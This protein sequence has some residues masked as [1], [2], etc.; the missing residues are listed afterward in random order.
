FDIRENAKKPRR[1]ERRSK[2]DAVMVASKLSNEFF[3]GSIKVKIPR[4]LMGRW[5]AG[6]ARVLPP[7]LL[8]GQYSSDRHFSQKPPV[9]RS[10]GAGRRRADRRH[11][12]VAVMISRLSLGGSARKSR[13]HSR[14]RSAMLSS[15]KTARRSD[16]WLVRSGALP[17][18]LEPIS[19]PFVAPG[20]FCSRLAAAVR[21]C[22][23]AAELIGRRV[24]LFGLGRMG[25]TRWP[26]ESRRRG[27]PR[28][29]RFRHAPGGR[30]SRDGEGRSARRAR[31][32]AT[33]R[34]RR[35]ALPTWRPDR[36]GAIR[37]PA[38]SSCLGGAP[39]LLAPPLRSGP[40]SYLLRSSLST[41]RRSYSAQR[42]CRVW[43]A[44][45][46]HRP[47]WRSV[48][49]QS[50]STSTLGPFSS[51]RR[52][53]SIPV[54]ALISRTRPAFRSLVAT[55]CAAAAFRVFGG[56]RQRSLRCNAS[57]RIANCVSVSLAGE[58]IG[59]ILSVLPALSPSPPRAPDRRR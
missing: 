30:R 22:G 37:S 16:T 55:F 48:P 10:E 40:T 36:V 7:S 53:A 47:R 38:R 52:Q 26:R 29:G 34:W 41:N 59:I 23:A 28:R 13:R 15:A 21:P 3:V 6:K 50:I 24:K 19:G 43:I 35:S 58:F 46:A 54:F 18:A 51:S 17:V 49:R 39:S 4:E 12:V 32:A 2:T 5:I 20:S 56:M 57:N 31:Y 27:R 42:P 14:R 9:L 11:R 25:I 45:R 33:T 8:V 1:A 44:S